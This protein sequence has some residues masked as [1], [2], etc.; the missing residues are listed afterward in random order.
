MDPAIKTGMI[1][2]VEVTLLIVWVAG[3]WLS[4]YLR[5]TETIS[6]VAIVLVA[7]SQA[8]H[9]STALM[10]MLLRQR[11]MLRKYNG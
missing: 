7:T 2:T 8:K 4:H 3:C 10:I 11:P 6:T 9:M 1:S 5:A